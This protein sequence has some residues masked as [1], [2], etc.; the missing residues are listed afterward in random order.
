MLLVEA[1][2]DLRSVHAPDL[3]DGWRLPQIEDW[4]FTAGD[5]QKLRRGRLV[6]GTG[7]LTRFAVRGAPADFERHEQRASARGLHGRL[8]VGDDADLIL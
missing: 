4:V 5:G 7:W 3:L 2:P 6:G 1:G 8:A